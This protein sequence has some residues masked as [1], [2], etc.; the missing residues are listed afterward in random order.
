MNLTEAKAREILSQA[1][2]IK[3]FATILEANVVAFLGGVGAASE[4]PINKKLEDVKGR[5][6]AKLYKTLKVK[7]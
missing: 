1:R 7:K 2:I 5:V 6:N 3:T 4:K